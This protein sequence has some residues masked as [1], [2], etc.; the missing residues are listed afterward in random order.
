[1]RPERTSTPGQVVVAE[2]QVPITLPGNLEDGIGYAGL[3]RGAAVVPH[4]IEPMPG[5]EEGDVDFRRVLF[6]ARQQE[7][8]EVVL[9]NAALRDVALLIHGVV[10]EPGNL[11]FDLLPDR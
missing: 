3:N 1:S 9:H 5:L 4:A 11:A 6:D 7:G 8:V 10:V 2:R